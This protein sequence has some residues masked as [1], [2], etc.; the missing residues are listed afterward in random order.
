MEYTAKSIAELLSGK[1]IGNPNVKVTTI[2]KIQDAQ[3]GSLC[4][5]ANSAYSNFLSSTK[6]SIVLINQDFI[7]EE[8]IDPTLI[9]VDDSYKAFAT[10]V[11]IY[12]KLKSSDL[13][14]VEEYAFIHKKA[15]IGNDVYIGSYSY[16]SS[17]AIIGDNVRIYPQVFVGENVEIGDNTVIYPGV[18]IYYD[19]KIDKN[20]I[21]HSGVVIG[22]DGFG[23]APQKDGTYIKIQQIGNVVI[24]SD[25]EIG[26]NT[27]ID[28]ATLGSTVIKSGVKLDNLIQ[29]AHNVEIGA[30]T[31][32]AAQTGIAGSTKIGNNCLIG[33]QVGFVGHIKI[34]DK[35][36]IGAQ[37]GITKSIIK[38]GTV[39]LGSPAFELTKFQRSYSVFKNLPEI[40]NEI[41]QLKKQLE[42][43]QKKV[44][45]QPEFV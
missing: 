33:G 2:S 24:E 7:P 45:N 14:G 31:V 1:V 30:N 26:A 27:V 40:R 6:A 44:E 28:R 39:L 12:Q 23:F 36:N 15:I 3:P 11:N 41:I 38:E 19:C 4:F 29:L 35:T 22:S 34:A 10:L 25:V 37:A 20:C 9:V 17:N 21:I 5:L 16:V 42:E 18:K 43:L 32:I 13:T 8:K